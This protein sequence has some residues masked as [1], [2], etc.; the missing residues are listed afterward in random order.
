MSDLPAHLPEQ[1]AAE[2]YE[3][4]VRGHLDAR[5]AARLSVPSLTHETDGT[6]ILHGIAADQAA[7]HGLLQRVR[8]LGLTLVSVVRV[9]PAASLPFNPS[10]TRTSK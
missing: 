6:T 4:I 2:T 8:D 10:N 3:I 5:W 7:L 9:S 1:T